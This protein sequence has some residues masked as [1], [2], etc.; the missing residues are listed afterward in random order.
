MAKE[1][2]VRSVA[3]AAIARPVN[4]LKTALL[5][6][7]RQVDSWPRKLPCQKISLASKALRVSIV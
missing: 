2:W 6:F 7:E 4:S 1:V 3:L 5:Q